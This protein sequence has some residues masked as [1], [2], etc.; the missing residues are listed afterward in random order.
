MANFRSMA[1]QL[2][3][4]AFSLGMMIPIL[5]GGINL[6]IVATAN[7]T[8]ILLL[9]SDPSLR[10]SHRSIRIV[11]HHSMAMVSLPLW[12]RLVEWF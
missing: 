2:P 3:L 12:A 5:S 4:L 8:G 7:F 11:G 1:Y 10:K 6:G 9:D